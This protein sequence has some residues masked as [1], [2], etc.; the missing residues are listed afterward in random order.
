MNKIAAVILILI[1]GSLVQVLFA[2][3]DCQNTPNRA[4]AEFSK[5]YFQLDESMAEKICTE[6]LTSDEDVDLVDKYVY[7]AAQEA[8]ARGFKTSFMQNKLYDI[9]TETISK[10]WTSAQIRITGKRR[11][12]INPVYPMVTKLFNLGAIHE[13]DEVL[14]LVKEDGKWKV[15][16]NFFTFPIQ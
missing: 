15:C 9:E 10:T 6:R 4:A 3:A 8:K 12:A 1:A 7:L 2:L 16:G 5:A 14:D 13:V 11:V